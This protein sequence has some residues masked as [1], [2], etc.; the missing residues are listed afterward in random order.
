[1][2]KKALDKLVALHKLIS[3]NFDLVA[4]EAMLADVEVGVAG[5]TDL[6]LRDKKTGKFAIFDY[7]TKCIEIDGKNTKKNGRKLWGFKFVN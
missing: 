6:I 7:K 4:S 3:D 1:M 5:T 2:S